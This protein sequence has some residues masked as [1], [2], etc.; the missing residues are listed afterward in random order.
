MPRSNQRFFST[1]NPQNE[2]MTKIR[3]QEIVEQKDGLTKKGIS[4]L[5]R[6]SVVAANQ[7]LL[8][9]FASHMIT[10]LWAIHARCQVSFDQGLLMQ[11]TGTPENMLSIGQYL[12]ALV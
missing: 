11:P 1:G 3:D 7:T 8:E 2:N 12:Q 6:S 9:H 4:S 10:V 5:E